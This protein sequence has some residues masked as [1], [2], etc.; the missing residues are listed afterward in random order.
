LQDQVKKIYLNLNFN[1]NFS[2]SNLLNFQVTAFTLCCST[3]SIQTIRIIMAV[4]R[5]K[6][7]M[8]I[9]FYI[10]THT[11]TYTHNDVGKFVIEKYLV[12][13]RIRGTLRNIVEKWVVLI[14]W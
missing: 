6:N 7:D 2:V 4:S 12:S 11:H 9:E 10:Y 1:I 3:Q 5:V 14:L 13:K 8:T